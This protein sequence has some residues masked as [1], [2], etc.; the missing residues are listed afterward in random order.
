VAS[1]KEVDTKD[2]EK[3]DLSAK[4]RELI[5]KIKS[6]ENSNKNVKTY[7]SDAEV[8]NRIGYRLLRNLSISCY[9]L[10]MCAIAVMCI[11]VK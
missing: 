6:L 1:E 3:A 9:Y 4:V 11:Q 8:R 2:V 5:A 7:S 10:K